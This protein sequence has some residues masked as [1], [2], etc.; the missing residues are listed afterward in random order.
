MADTKLRSSDEILRQLQ[1]KSPKECSLFDMI[2]MLL[3]RMAETG[4]TSVGVRLVIAGEPFVLTLT[5][6][7]PTPA[8]VH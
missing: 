8:T 7:M 2:D 1:D 3:A 5:A 6:M 4:Q